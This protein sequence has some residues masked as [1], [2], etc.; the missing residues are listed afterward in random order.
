MSTQPIAVLRDTEQAAS[1]LQ[2][3]R[4][5]LVELL[6]EP[7]TAAG[8]ARRLGMRRQVVNYHLRQLE[9]QG[10]LEVVAERRQGTR[11][12]RVLRARAR[13][14]LI[15]P[16]ALGEIG[17]DP[18]R[19]ADRLSASYLLAVAARVIRQL[20]EALARAERAKQRV[21]TL[22]LTSPIR[23]R[24]AAERNA[25]AEELTG[26]VGE[27]IAKYHDERMSGGR[28]FELVVGVYPAPAAAPSLRAVRGLGWSAVPPT[29]GT[30]CAIPRRA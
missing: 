21:A 10:V 17:T 18:A 23:F 16:D 15:G 3:L 29:A 25:F 12:E 19:V 6:Q 30:S 11:T 20:G 13:S 14:Y 5:R 24:S 26:A 27:L 1:L 22:T 9:A 2:P 4:L 28:R 8:L 7:D